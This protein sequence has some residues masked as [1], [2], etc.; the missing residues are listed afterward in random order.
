MTE[1]GIIRDIIGKKLT[2]EISKHIS[3][4]NED[5]ICNLYKQNLRNEIDED[6]KFDFF[7]SFF[8][9]SVD[10]LQDKISYIVDGKECSV[11]SDVYPRIDF[12]DFGT[13]TENVEF[14][15]SYVNVET[16]YEIEDNVSDDKIYSDKHDSGELG[17]NN[18]YNS[19][20]ESIDDTNSTNTVPQDNEEQNNLK[21]FY[22]ESTDSYPEYEDSGKTDTERQGFMPKKKREQPK[23]LVSTNE[24]FIFSQM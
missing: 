15:S 3:N 9:K 11:Q 17:E 1:T 14:S 6:A 4:L 8:R 13:N 16:Q 19:D 10:K 7:C 21:Y 22:M 23:K 12:K 2:N 5:E 24:P 20:N 18:E